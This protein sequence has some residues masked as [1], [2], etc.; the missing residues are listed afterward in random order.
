MR[1]KIYIIGANIPTSLLSHEALK[2]KE[3]IINP[4][5]MKEIKFTSKPQLIEL[6]PDRLQQ[7][8][9]KEKTNQSWKSKSGKIIRK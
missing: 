8:I 3:V 9:F 2:D 6:L 5:Y 7:N 1:D 4:E